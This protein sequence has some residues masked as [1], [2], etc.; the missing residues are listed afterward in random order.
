MNMKLILSVFAVLVIAAM[1][2]SALADF[3]VTPSVRVTDN[4]DTSRTVDIT[5]TNTGVAGDESLNFSPL[6]Y[7]GETRDNDDD[8]ITFLFSASPQNLAPGASATVT[9]TVNIAQNV[10]VDTYTGNVDVTATVN[11]TSVTKQVAS[12]VEVI[13]M[14]CKSG[15]NGNLDVSVNEPDSGETFNPGEG[16]ELDVTVENNDDN[17]MDVKVVATLYDLTE[18]DEIKKVT[19]EVREVQDGDDKDFDLTLTIPTNLDEDDEY[20]LYV[21]AYEDGR[22]SRNCDFEG[23]EI[24]LERESHDTVV[25]EV[26]FLPENP[27]C[28]EKVT[29]QAT[30]QNAGTENEDDVYVKFIAKDFNVNTESEKFD[31]DEYGDRDDDYVAQFTFTLP[32]NAKGEYFPESIVSYN[33]GDENSLVQKL[34]VEC[35]SAST[36][37]DETDGS[38]AKLTVANNNLKLDSATGKFVLEL[39]LKNN[40]EEAL[41]VNV[42]VT[43]AQWAEVLG[44]E[45]PAVLNP[46]DVFHAY[47]YLKLKEGTQPGPHNLRVNLRKE[48]GLI[49]SQ[50]VSVN[51]PENEAPAI[52]GTVTQATPSWKSWFTGRPKL[53]WVVADLVLVA[54]AVLFIRLLFKK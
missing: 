5:I 21:K 52:T 6:A 28:G 27:M 54:L 29:A 35:G 40:G 20:V 45:A 37:A 13:P 7:T 49:E 11:G 30:I 51:V 17:D 39:V 53:F 16:I 18:N 12:R 15:R 22:E 47:A 9:M 26:K 34:T 41:P 46:G 36:P 32:K 48:S 10:D 50:L 4:E 8:A 19:S 3:T 1:S 31:L 2:V 24:D 38:D 44:V 25:K 14:V 33:D 42:D 23:P 43:E